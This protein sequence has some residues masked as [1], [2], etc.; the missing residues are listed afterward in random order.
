MPFDAAKRAAKVKNFHF[1][2][3]RHCA[4]TRWVLA[5]MPEE[6]RK[7]AAGHRRGSVHQRSINPPYEQIVKIFT[8]RLGWKTV[9]D[10]STRELRQTAE[11]VK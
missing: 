6:L 1:H 9:D 11:S 5:G 3:F 10:A 2:D 8:D 4:V 7:I